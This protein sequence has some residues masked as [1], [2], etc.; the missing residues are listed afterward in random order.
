M[1]NI[2]MTTMLEKLKM[3]TKNNQVTNSELDAYIQNKLETKPVSEGGIR[4]YIH[5]IRLHV[6]ITNDKGHKG[7]VC[8]TSDG[9]YVTY[10]PYEILDHLRSFEG[11][12]NKM[13]QVHRK[14][15]SILMDKV[16]YKQQKFEFD[17]EPEKCN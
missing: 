8:G 16:Y 2:I 14:G 12:I 11:K 10:N 3:T 6:D 13:M 4:A 15:M 9:Y 17:G 7:W 5:H 1:E